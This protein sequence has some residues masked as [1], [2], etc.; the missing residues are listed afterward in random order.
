MYRQSNLSILLIGPLCTVIFCAAAPFGC[1]AQPGD[2]N[3]STSF[4]GA[5]VWYEDDEPLYNIIIDGG[6][7]ASLESTGRNAK[8]LRYVRS[9]TGVDSRD[10]LTH[11]SFIE[12]DGSRIV[13]FRF[14][15]DSRG[16][17]SDE[18]C[19]GVR[20]ENIYSKTDEIQLRTSSEAGELRRTD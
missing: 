12:G 1:G 3:G 19:P 5:W 2:P 11:L 15:Q 7:I 16:C 8:G 6:E 14:D 20:S 17:T 13:Q 4:D 10:G 18:L 9:I